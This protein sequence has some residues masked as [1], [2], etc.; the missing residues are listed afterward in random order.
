VGTTTHGAMRAFWSASLSASLAI[1]RPNPS[2]NFPDIT[3]GLDGLAEGRHRPN[4]VLGALAHE[5]LLLKRVAWAETAGAKRDHPEQRIVVI[6]INPNLIGEGCRHAATTT[7]SMAATAVV[8]S[9]YLETFGGDI[10]EVRVGAFQLAYWRAHRALQWRRGLLGR[11]MPTTGQ[12][13][14]DQTNNNSADCP[15]HGA[16]PDVCSLPL[17]HGG[18]P[19]Y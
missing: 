9:V 17:E 2:D 16:L 8:R 1:N 11:G 6:A 18:W 19:N 15:G 14:Y 7:A 4:H 10:A 12:R 13:G 3:I 5:P